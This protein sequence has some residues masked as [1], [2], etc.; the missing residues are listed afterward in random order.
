MKKYMYRFIAL[1]L[2][3]GL[4]FDP[5]TA[6][7]MAFAQEPPVPHALSMRP[8]RMGVEAIPAPMLC[9]LA[10][11]SPKHSAWV[12]ALVTTLPMIGMAWMTHFGK[13]D[14]VAQ[15]HKIT[16]SL[17]HKRWHAEGR[18]TLPTV[19]SFKEY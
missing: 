19:K 1:F 2:V 17:P 6:Q 12:Y 14:R 4:I 10:T 8:N 11:F 16:I 7:A 18:L 3:A 15:L 5:M 9:S 13:R